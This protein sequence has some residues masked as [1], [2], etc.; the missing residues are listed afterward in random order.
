MI[1][2]HLSVMIIKRRAIIGSLLAPQHMLVLSS[3]EKM[4]D[5]NGPA[6]LW[7]CLFFSPTV[8]GLVSHLLGY[9]S[10]LQLRSKPMRL[11][12]AEAN[13]FIS[14]ATSSQF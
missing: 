5:G 8:R 10:R 1:T 7:F 12:V 13:V 2:F 6:F 11:V 4:S 3:K 14:V 9:F